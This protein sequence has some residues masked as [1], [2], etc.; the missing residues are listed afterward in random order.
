[1]TEP[2]SRT[3]LIESKIDKGRSGEIALSLM[4]GL[5]LANLAEAFEIAK[6]MAISGPCVPKYL[7]QNPGSCLYH[8]MRGA[9]WRMDPF[10]IAEDSYIVKNRKTGE[11]RISY[12]SRTIHAVVERNAPIK[13][14]LSCVYQGEGLERTCTVKGIFTDGEEREYTTPTVGS[15]RARKREGDSEGAGGAGSPLWFSD[16]D[17]QLFYHASRAWARKWC[18]DVLLG[19]FSREELEEAGFEE[20]PAKDLARMPAQ[21]QIE[22]EE[23]LSSRLSPDAVKRAGFDIAKIEDE[24]RKNGT[25]ETSAPS[26]SGESRTPTDGQTGGEGS[27]SGVPP[28]DPSPPPEPEAAG[29]APGQHPLDAAAALPQTDAEYEAHVRAYCAA[30]TD[31]DKLAKL[32]KGERTMRGKIPNLTSE[33]MGACKQIVEERCRELRGQSE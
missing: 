18:P 1:M 21:A 24:I 22:H 3:D 23:S 5:E 9:R 8:V 20:I 31:A 28:A 15:I 26:T 12:G 7:Q 10:A 25:Q 2:T 6:A 33:G 19:A 29:T 17:Q 4:G 16:P 30:A 27:D 11:E 13:R 32:W 14:R